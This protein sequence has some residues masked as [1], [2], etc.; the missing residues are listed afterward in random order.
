[1]DRDGR[2]QLRPRGAI[3]EDGMSLALE[4][5]QTS[6][7]T[8]LRVKH[9]RFGV[10]CSHQLAIGFLIAIEFLAFLL[11]CVASLLILTESQG[12]VPLISRPMFWATA[13][14]AGLVLVQELARARLLDT[15]D[16]RSLRGQAGLV[17]S[18]HC[19]IFAGVALTSLI[20]VGVH[21]QFLQWLLLSLA[22]SAPLMLTTRIL[23]WNTL[24]ALT[25]R[26]I[27]TY[28][29]AV[30]GA[31]RDG[32]AFV[33]LL[34]RK[35]SP[36]VKIV[37][38]FDDR[39]RSESRNIPRKVRNF[40]V[41][42]T[43]CD[44]LAFARRVR[45]DAVV[46]AMPWTASQRVNEL[47][48]ALRS[49]STNVYLAPDCAG[50]AFLD[51]TLTSQQDFPAFRLS[52]M[53]V[54]GWPHIAKW[55]FDKT[56]ALLALCLLS[57]L[58]AL[59]CLAVRLDSS[60]PILF[61]QRRYGFNGR[62]INI[63]KF[64]TMYHESLDV[65]ASVLVKRKDPR[66]TRVGHFLRRTSLDELPQLLNVLKGDMSIVGPRPHALQA[67]ADGR[68]YQDV[69]CDYALRHRIK[70]GITGWAQIKGWRGETDTV[71]KLVRRV[72]HDLYYIEHWSLLLDLYIVVATPFV[73]P[74]Q[75][76]AY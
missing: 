64:R 33:D 8:H 27:L 15:N 58:L 56:V 34:A 5:L 72:E 42:G 44:L 31:G 35:G 21:Y 62:I 46:I 50:L 49:L 26:R 2:D 70:P 59:I 51:R 14:P 60:G 19:L 25:H 16:D 45:V 37:G 30:I 43:A 55:F 29:V 40:S 63:Y 28:N 54:E 73:L 38:V 76:N 4:E 67:K 1:M 65:D 20:A 3:M 57:P 17:L 7:V 74:F 61:Q 11:A 6:Q 23:F 41:R 18:H 48:T 9:H 52:R 32:S 53:P 24:R 36:L 47:L 22:I 39:A 10:S 12:R 13:I 71:E 68:L 66:V 75:R 69:V